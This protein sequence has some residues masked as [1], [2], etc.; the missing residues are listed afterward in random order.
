MTRMMMKIMF[1]GFNTLSSFHVTCCAWN[2]KKCFPG[3]FPTM[4][5][6]SGTN[7]YHVYFGTVMDENVAGN[8][9]FSRQ[10]GISYMK[11]RG[12]TK[13]DE[14]WYRNRSVHV[15]N[16]VLSE[17]SD[18]CRDRVE[19]GKTGPDHQE[20]PSRGASG[21]FGPVSAGPSLVGFFGPFLSFSTWRH[22]CTGPGNVEK[23]NYA[24]RPVP[25]RQSKA[26]DDSGAKKFFFFF[27]PKNGEGP[28][29]LNF[30]RD[31][32]GPSRYVGLLP[33]FG[34][35]Q[36]TRPQIDGATRFPL[37]GP[38]VSIFGRGTWFWA[39]PKK[40][41]NFMPMLTRDGLEPPFS[42][43]IYRGKIMR[44]MEIE[45]LTKREISSSAN[46]ILNTDQMLL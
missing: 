40:Y 6:Q 26:P 33:I 38:L 22:S 10:P 9:S 32:H 36:G 35:T 24:F 15:W 44:N 13:S 34:A 4:S 42:C 45:L 41:E 39:H 18:Y 17:K 11:V 27:W 31:I 2:T 8:L 19:P 30:R 7:I 25:D 43:S 5:G 20:A 14:K 37:R 16:V 21:S 12:F 1:W 23:K 28:G 29:P 46:K 3:P